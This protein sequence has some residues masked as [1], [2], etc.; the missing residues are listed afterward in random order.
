MPSRMLL[1]SQRLIHASTLDAT[2]RSQLRQL[3]AQ[4][5]ASGEE[6]GVS[7]T[8]LTSVTFYACDSDNKRASPI[9]HVDPRSLQE[10]NTN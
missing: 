10:F 4:M 9:M 5:A 8:D 3:L 2:T 7:I 6:G 1:N